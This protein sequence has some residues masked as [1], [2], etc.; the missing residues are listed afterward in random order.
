MAERNG[1]RKSR[2]Q[3][4][5]RRIP[6]LGYYFIVT[7]TKET[8]QNYILGLRNSIPKELQGKL[9]IRVS[10]AK[11]TRLIDDA[12]NM[13]SLHPQ[14]GEPWIV[15]DR[16]QITG[17][18]RLIALAIEKGI[19]VGWSNPC[20]EIWFNA[21]F[22][23]MPTYSDSVSCCYGFGNTYSR[24]SGQIYQKSDEDIYTKLCRYGDERRAFDLAK[25]KYLEHIRNY[26]TEPSDMCPATTLHILVE[27]IKKKIA[28]DGT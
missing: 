24:L 8:E 5:K 3:L 20:I 28:R 14:Y 1:R 22:G 16:D 25:K 7:D 9:V 17:F 15:F 13:A 11:T 19:N 4:S 2:E 10:K 18:D 12:L 6:K 23:I 26:K 21:Y 27:E